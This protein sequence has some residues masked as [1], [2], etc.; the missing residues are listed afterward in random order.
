[1]PSWN[2]T[3]ITAL[4]E[5]PFFDL[6]HQAHIIHKEHFNNEMQLA[7]LLNIKT[8]GCPE[9]CKYCSQSVHY[10][11]KLEIEKLMQVEDIVAQAKLAQQ[12]GATRFCMGAGWRTPTNRNLDKVCDAIKAVK[13][14]GMETCVTLGMLN[15]QQADTLKQAGLDFYNH[16]IDTSEEYYS[17]VITTRTFEDRIN[18]IQK[19]RDAG[20]K[21]CTGGILGLGESREDRISFIETLANLDPALESCTI[22]KLIPIPGTP[23]AKKQG[24]DSFEFIR[25]VAVAR[26]TMPN[27][28]VRLSAG[29]TTMDDSTQA[30]IFYAGA[31]SIFI[32]DKLLTTPNPDANHDMN[33]LKKCGLKAQTLNMCEA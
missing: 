7:T 24:V 15:Q 28:Y 6:I 31:N 22:N 32:G 26:I 20:M 10:D 21:V 5:L 23:L 12:N 17:E 9:D 1:M 30:L 25:T 19:V 13:D 11:S 29:R 18:T 16:N 8:G 4:F 33:L 14:L 2:K 27:T 3:Q